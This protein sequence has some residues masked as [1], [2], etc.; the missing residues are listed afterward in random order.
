MPWCQCVF[1]LTITCGGQP[2]SKPVF[3][4]SQK[5]RVPPLPP[6]RDGRLGSPGGPAP[7]PTALHVLFLSVRV[8][9]QF[10][11]SP[12]PDVCAI[13][14]AYSSSSVFPLMSV[15]PIAVG[16]KDS[17]PTVS[18]SNSTSS[19]TTVTQARTSPYFRLSG[20]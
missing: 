19:W 3:C 16:N 14:H 10:T 7:F 2:L 17:L 1:G 13:F 6:R 20:V 4:P 15:Q 12:T 8:H 9:V 5:S 18:V 11:P